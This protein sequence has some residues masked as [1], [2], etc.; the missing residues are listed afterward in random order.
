HGYEPVPPQVVSLMPQ[1]GQKKQQSKGKTHEADQEQT[2]GLLLKPNE[3]KYHP[4]DKQQD[5]QQGIGAADLQVLVGRRLEEQAVD[6]PGQKEAAPARA[7]G[8][9]LAGRSDSNGHDAEQRHR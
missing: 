5:S 8:P 2:A 1:G 7:V 9:F 3:R 4:G 6:S